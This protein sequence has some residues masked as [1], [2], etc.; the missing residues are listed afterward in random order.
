MTVF[1]TNDFADMFD[2]A[3]NLVA[4][5]NPSSILDSVGEER[6]DAIKVQDRI[7]PRIRGWVA[8]DKLTAEPARAPVAPRL[9]VPRFIEAAQD[10]AN[11]VNR[12]FGADAVELSDTLLLIFAWIDSGWENVGEAIPVPTGAQPETRFGPFG[13]L[14]APWAATIANPKY[15]EILRDFTEFSRIDPYLQCYVA[16]CLVNDLQT[17]L[18]AVTG[19]APNSTLIRIAYLVGAEA[20]R[21]FVQLAQ[22]DKVDTAVGGQPALSAATIAAHGDLFNSGVPP[23]TRAK[24]EATVAAQL[25]E[26]A[27]A[28]A[29][30]AA[31]FLKPLEPLAGGAVDAFAGPKIL[32]DDRG[33]DLLSRVAMSEVGHFGRH[34]K[35]Q[36]E[37][38][39]AGV[40]DTIINRVAHPKFPN[41]LEGVVN[42]PKQFSAIND[43][44]TWEKLPAPS[45]TVANIVKAHVVARCKGHASAIR[46]AV[47]FLNPF[48]SDAS[49]LRS[50]GQHVVDNAVAVYGDE[51]AHD[52][53]FH[54]FAPGTNPPPPYALAH[55]TELQLF[56]GTGEPI[57]APAVADQVAAIIA[58]AR[59]EWAHWGKAVLDVTT[60][61]EKL[62]RLHR[63]DEPDFSLY[64]LHNYCSLVNASTIQSAIEDDKFAWSAACLSFILIQAG[65]TRQQFKFS[66]SH[67]TYIRDAVAKKKAND[68]SA[69]Y[70]GYRVDDPL[71]IPEPGD[72]IGHARPQSETDV[73]THQKALTFYDRTQPYKSHADIVVAKRPGQID[74]IGGNVRDSVTM[75]TLRIGT[76]GHLVEDQF[77]WFVVMKRRA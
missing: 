39:L 24:V 11:T 23:L 29:A 59:K 32:I 70:W 30:K 77:F 14:P 56:S 19:A 68:T 9:E 61:P 57:A 18:H 51:A 60:M 41:S 48:S 66:E 40:V 67:S 22:G 25:E 72:I 1:F 42:A 52:V 7:D 75:K 6:P 46:G 65:I 26:A 21:R 54:G 34:G 58:S 17:A 64:V 50:W 8:R 35:K 55:K 73:M 27:T 45:A 36:L 76:T 13:F 3:G 74:V 12:A 63:D 69:L 49:A 44:G 5:F 71:A 10:A 38:G 62:E 15:A 31:E 33:L 20:G 43:I 47:N 53:H 4:I 16:A 37:G 28:A 2:D